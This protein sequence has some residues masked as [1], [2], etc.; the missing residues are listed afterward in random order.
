[1]SLTLADPEQLSRQRRAGAD[2][3]DRSPL[4]PRSGMQLLDAAI[5]RLRRDPLTALA[6]SLVTSAP[7]AVAILLLHEVTRSEV[8]VWVQQRQQAIQQGACL[9]IAILLPLRHMAQVAV[10]RS[11]Y[12]DALEGSPPPRRL[13]TVAT[14]S[15]RGLALAFGGLF[16][17]LPGALLAVRFGLAPAIGAFEDKHTERALQRSWRLSES[18]QAN[19]KSALLPLLLLFVL[20]VLNVHLGLPW[21]LWLVSFAG[22]VEG[23]ALIAQMRFDNLSYLGPLLAVSWVALD[24]IW[25]LLGAEIYRDSIIREEGHDLNELLTAFERQLAES[26]APAP[27]AALEPVQEATR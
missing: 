15:L 2:D 8:T 17:L 21:L 7:L 24:P 16:F 1:M 12:A 9:A 22:G 18:S 5:D 3:L 19:S 26:S 13:P 10:I 25:P 23:S 27:A 4:A 11:L 14:G 20:L 6:G